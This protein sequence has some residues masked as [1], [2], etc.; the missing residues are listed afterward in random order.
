MGL[1]GNL[2]CHA[3]L[4]FILQKQNNLFGA[5][6]HD[7]STP[8]ATSAVRATGAAAKTGCGARHRTVRNH[9]PPSLIP[10]TSKLFDLQSAVVLMS[11]NGLG[12][13]TTCYCYCIQTLPTEWMLIQHNGTTEA[14]ANQWATKDL[15]LGKITKTGVSADLPCLVVVQVCIS[16]EDYWPFLFL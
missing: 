14:A 9:G 1:L 11:V 15:W 2:T 10:F 8:P 13:T 7:E 5:S 3:P 16:S 6:S 12:V 4:F